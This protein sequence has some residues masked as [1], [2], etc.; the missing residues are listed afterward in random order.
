MNSSYSFSFPYQLLTLYCLSIPLFTYFLSYGLV[1]LIIVSWTHGNDDGYLLF[2]HL[3]NY[4]HDH[5]DIV[6]LQCLSYCFIFNSLPDSLIGNSNIDPIIG[7]NNSKV[8][9]IIEIM[10]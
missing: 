10:L 4:T 2:T 1:Q 7:I 9:I 3:V 6:R 8:I 5:N